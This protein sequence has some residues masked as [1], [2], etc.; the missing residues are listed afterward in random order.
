MTDLGQGAAYDIN[1]AGQVVGYIVASGGARVAGTWSGDSDGGRAPVGREIGTLGGLESHAMAINSS[2]QIVGWAETSDGDRHA[3]LYSGCSMVDLN[4]AIDANSG[5]LLQAASDINDAGQIV[6]S[7]QIDGEIHAFL[8]TPTEPNW[9]GDI[10]GDGDVDLGDLATLL[11]AYG[12]CDGD[13]GYNLAADLDGS[14]C[15]DL[16]DLAALLANYGLER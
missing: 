6:G 16:L 12:T 13:P 5:W 7:G 9:P 11:A 10:D 4:D 8:L 1:D 15:I 14:G 2:G 3:F